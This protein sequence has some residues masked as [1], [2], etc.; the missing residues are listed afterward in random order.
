MINILKYLTGVRG[1]EAYDTALLTAHAKRCVPARVQAG[2]YIIEVDG[3]MIEIMRRG[4]G[5][6]RGCVGWW[7]LHEVRNR[8]VGDPAPTLHDALWS[9]GIGREE[10]E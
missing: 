1:L 2:W 3:D 4:P 9:I 6:D 5:D 8:W 10:G 7:D